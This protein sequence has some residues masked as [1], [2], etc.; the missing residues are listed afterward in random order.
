MPYLI[1][2]EHVVWIKILGFSMSNQSITIDFPI[3]FSLHFFLPSKKSKGIG[4]W[5][6][7][8]SKYCE[9]KFDNFKSPDLIAISGRG[10]DWWP[11]LC[12]NRAQDA[13]TCHKWDSLETERLDQKIKL[14]EK[15]FVRDWRTRHMWPFFLVCLLQHMADCGWQKYFL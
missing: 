14:V 9:T 5:K 1:Y 4:I 13:K 15:L 2:T 12:Q 11:D 3:N 6:D 8:S 10:L 7:K